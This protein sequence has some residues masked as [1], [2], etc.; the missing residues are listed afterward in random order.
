MH[1]RQWPRCRR[2][3]C[4]M[5]RKTRTRAWATASWLGGVNHGP[6]LECNNGEKAIGKALIF[7]MSLPQTSQLASLGRLLARVRGTRRGDMHAPWFSFLSASPPRRQD[8]GRLLHSIPREKSRGA[9]ARHRDLSYTMKDSPVAESTL[10]NALVIASSLS[11]SVCVDTLPRMFQ[12][13]RVVELDSAI[14]FA[15]D[16][17]VRCESA[18]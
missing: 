11:Q 4:I 3:A 13:A 8:D 12:I 5:F 6:S 1:L 9:K 15:E 17:L 14:H 2:L 16:R 18:V 10:T 7:G